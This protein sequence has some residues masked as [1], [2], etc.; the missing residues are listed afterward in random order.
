MSKKLLTEKYTCLTIALGYFIVSGAW[1][2]VSNKLF[3]AL[4]NRPELADQPAGPGIWFFIA[5][6]TGMLYWL[7]RYWDVAIA[8]SQESLRKVNRSLRSFSECTKAMTRIDDELKLMEEVCRVCVE[9]GGHRMA[10]VAFKENDADRTVRPVTSW[11]AQGCF[12]DELNA[13]WKDEPQGWG[14]AGTTIRT[15]K[16]TV[17]H[18]L[19]TNPL[20]RPWRSLA[21][22]CGYTSCIALPLI[23]GGETFAALVIFDEKSHAFDEDEAQL[24]EELAEDLAYGI[25][26]LRLKVDSQREMEERLMLATVMDQTSDGVITFDAE[27]TI[28]YLNPSFVALCGV[29]AE[30]SIGVNIH[31]FECSKRNPAFYRALLSVFTTNK[32]LSG[33]FVNKKRDGS[34]YDMDA[35]IAPVFDQN[36]GVVRYVAIIRDVSEAIS[37]QQQLRQAQKMEAMATLSG[38][39]AHDFNNILAIII[40][41]MEMTLEDVPVD[42][43]LHGSME[44]VLK[45]GLRGKN[46]VKQFMTISRQTEQ[47]QKIVNLDDII[48]ECLPMLRATIPTTIELRKHVD[49]DSALIAADPT[50]INQV[51]MNLCANA[52]DAMLTKG[53]ILDISLSNV[54]LREEDLPR[55]P[56]LRAGQ[57]IK[58][59]IADTGHGMT[60]DVVD[61][62]F[63]PFY[64]TKMPGKGTGLGLSVVHGII[65]NHRG[66]IAVNSI[67]EVGTTFT[68]LFPHVENVSAPEEV[69]MAQKQIPGRGHIL[70]VD[71][72][73]D[74][75]SGMKNALERLG[76]IVTAETDSHKTLERFRQTPDLFDLVITDQTMPHLT[77]VMLA[78]ELLKIRPDVP[79]ILCSGSSPG[80]DAAVSPAK[81]KAAGIREVLMKP[82]ERD[83]IHSVVQHI[84]NPHPA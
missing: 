28:Q 42:S 37:L 65:K 70:F 79:I 84:L 60:R 15:G 23:E 6:S 54:E 27:G 13:T 32:S 50:Q 18:N 73:V 40:T 25:K 57:Y 43:P 52:G 76:Y 48:K 82:V 11:G 12:L 68:I 81:A 51:I 80:S 45:A 47:P 64:T 55:Y 69:P 39:I 36:G 8:D 29:P 9:V 67:V 34:E 77:G 24:L 58:L 14:P 7:L 22:T 30:D 49:T 16:I 26:A 31:D 63:D 21:E 62:I 61:R 1:A 74:Y 41:N 66:N 72:E 20:Y 3:S 38:G 53:G 83:E 46:L 56:G 17:F 4:L 35:L 5:L 59:V 71:D 44:L 2:L 33:H 10:W 78:E 19:L 75:V